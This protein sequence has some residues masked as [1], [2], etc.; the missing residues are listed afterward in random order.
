[1][2][3]KPLDF[4]KMP[5]FDEY[6]PVEMPILGMKEV[7]RKKDNKRYQVLICQGEQGQEVS[8]FDWALCERNGAPW[9]LKRALKTAL[10]TAK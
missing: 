5:K 9:V 10:D 4:G 7:V 6:V 1:M 2:T 8:L 3:E